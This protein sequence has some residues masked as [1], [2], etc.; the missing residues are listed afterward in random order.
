MK[1]VLIDANK[2][3][4]KEFHAYF[5]KKLDIKGYYGENLDAMY[6]VF[7]TLREKI[8]IYVYNYNKDNLNEYGKSVWST[9]NELE[10]GKENIEI[11]KINIKRKDY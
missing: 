8:T 4:N 9:L 10:I 11:K 7:S 2:M 3:N 1:I 5:K 6:D